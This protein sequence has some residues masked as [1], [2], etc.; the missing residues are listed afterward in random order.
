VSVRLLVVNGCSFTFG[1]ELD[2][3]A[4][5]WGSVVAEALDVDLANLAV[6]GGSNRRI[7]RTS[8]EFLSRRLATGDLD[9]SEVLVLVMWAPI[10]RAEVFDEGA[11]DPVGRSS[12]LP[13]DD[14]HWHRILPWAA[15]RNDKVSKLYYRHL[16]SDAG[17]LHGFLLDW[18]LLQDFLARRGFGFRFL[19]ARPLFPEYPAPPRELW[20]LVDDERVLGGRAGLDAHA[21]SVCVGHGPF[22]PRGHPLAAAHRAFAHEVV[23]PWIRSSA[24]V[25]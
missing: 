24:V 9:P 18:V 21:F 22:G 3:R 19:A 5:A 13:D 8:V 7:V 2:S 12:S 10:E 25:G 23:V 11:V 17:A 1:D 16:Y 4:E 14:Q 15:R 20:D 6:S